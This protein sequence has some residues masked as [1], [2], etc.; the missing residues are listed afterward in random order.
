MVVVT[1]TLRTPHVDS[2]GGLAELEAP[3]SVFLKPLLLLPTVAETVAYQFKLKA[4]FYEQNLGV[5]IGTK[6]SAQIQ[7]LQSPL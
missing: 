5:I 7:D 6:Y 3:H 2:V 1:H 4:P